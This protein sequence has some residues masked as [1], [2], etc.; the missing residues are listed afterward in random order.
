M[1]V[2]DDA[3]TNAKHLRIVLVDDSKTALAQLQ[4]MIDEIE[5]VEV[6]ATVNDGAGAIRAFCS[7][8]FD[9]AVLEAAPHADLLHAE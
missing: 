6:V 9:T 2:D 3:M 7:K 5:A 8:P 1:N 4:A